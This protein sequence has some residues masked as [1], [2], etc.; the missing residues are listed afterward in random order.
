MLRVLS[1]SKNYDLILQKRILESG[2]PRFQRDKGV[3]REGKGTVTVL[4]SIGD[5]KGQ[6]Q[7]DPLSKDR[8]PACVC[9]AFK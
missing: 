2:N 5:E 1:P 9:I 4:V 7:E 6:E 8:N 3:Y